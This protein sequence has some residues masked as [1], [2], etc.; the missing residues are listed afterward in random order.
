LSAKKIINQSFNIGSFIVT[1][2]GVNMNPSALQCKNCW[3][4]GHM[5][6]ACCFQGSQC[7]KYNS[8]H[9]TEYH[10]HFGWCYKANFKINLS[11]LETKQNE[12]S[13]HTFKYI[14]CKGNYQANSNTCLFW[15]HY[16][17]KEWYSKKYQELCESQN[18]STCSAI[19]AIQVWF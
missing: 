7:I 2:R 13:S 3:K 19:S 14:N 5:T 18:N 11:C 4:W 1:I 17:N 9:K 15:H 6:F 12:P 8:P 10:Y 16:F